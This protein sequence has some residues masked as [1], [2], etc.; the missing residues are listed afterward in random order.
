M[1][2][3]NKKYLLEYRRNLRVRE[4][5]AETIFWQHVRG[6]KLNGLK[7]KRQHS[8]GNYIVDFYCASEM[9][10]IEL[11]GSVHNSKE[12][13]EKDLLRDENLREINFKVLRFKNQEILTDIDT[14][15]QK[16]LK[17]ISLLPIK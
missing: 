4:T 16:I 11:D 1:D 6:G 2:V 10:V 13:K 5:F 17:T 7:F 3:H 9:L 14:V 15:K 12:Q 8:I